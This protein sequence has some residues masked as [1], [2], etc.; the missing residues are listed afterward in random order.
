MIAVEPTASPLTAVLADARSLDVETLP[1][2]V[3]VFAPHADDESLGCGG[4]LALLRDLGRTVVP[5]LVTDGSASHAN[6]RRFGARARTMLRD[7]EWTEALR[8]LGVCADRAVRLGFVDGD[9]PHPADPRFAAAARRFE[10][11]LAPLD[12]GLVVLP[13]RRDPH[14]DHRATNAL[15]KAALQALGARPRCLEYVVWAGER[16]L[17]ADLPRRGEAHV[18]RLDIAAALGRKRAA[19]AAH[20]SQHGQIILDDPHGFVIAPEM[21]RR[22]EQPIEYFFECGFA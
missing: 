6:S 21:R 3:A 2:E 15:V 14:P 4:L 10:S 7:G 8:C 17:P 9:V 12:G 16:G 22:A 11:L 13:W 5:V 19:I 20:R 1:A 18:W